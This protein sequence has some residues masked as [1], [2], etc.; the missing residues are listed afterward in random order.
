MLLL[1]IYDDRLAI[2]IYYSIRRKYKDA[3]ELSVCEVGVL[4]P[5]LCST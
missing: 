4:P 5:Q 1:Q 2:D 3:A